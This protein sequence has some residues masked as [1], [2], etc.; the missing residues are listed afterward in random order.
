MTGS[1][2]I[3]PPRSWFAVGRRWECRKAVSRPARVVDPGYTHMQMDWLRPFVGHERCQQ[4]MREVR[5]AALSNS[6]AGR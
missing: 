4:A 1:L 5:V 2:R 6:G 3:W